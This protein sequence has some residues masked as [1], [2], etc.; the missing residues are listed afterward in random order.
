MPAY[1][2]IGDVHGHA[3]QLERTLRGL[4]YHKTGGVYE[5]P[6]RR[7]IYVGDIIN[8]GPQVRKAVKIVRAMVDHGT[9]K[10]V[11]GNH[12]IDYIRFMTTDRKGRP[13]LKHNR[14]SHLRLRDTLKSYDEHERL[15]LRDWL[16]T[17]P[18]YIDKRTY[19]VV[20][21]CWQD[22]EISFLEDKYGGPY[23]QPKLLRRLARPHKRTHWAVHSITDGPQIIR[24][25]DN[26]LDVSVH[27]PRQSSVKVK[28][29]EDAQDKSVRNL[30]IRKVKKVSKKKLPRTYYRAVDPY[31]PDAQPLFYGHY[32]LPISPRLL[33]DNICCLDFCVVKDK[34]LAVYR[35]D[36]EQTLEPA[37]LLSFE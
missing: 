24:N 23:I 21:A 22:T 36:G 12:E 34:R 15:D 8:R 9:A 11:L 6:D 28:W 18:L 4:G 37:R 32:C 31:P 14:W 25:D 2:I 3:A 16:M 10:M 29:W 35:F 13:L 33:G 26:K 20:H 17:Q 27:T 1:D 30:A 7:V 19:R 5:H